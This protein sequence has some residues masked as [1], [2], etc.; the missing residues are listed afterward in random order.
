[1]RPLT[2]KRP[3]SSGPTSWGV[4]AL[5]ALVVVAE[6]YDLIV[7]GALLPSLLTEPGWG[8]DNAGAGTVGSLVHVGVSAAVLAA[9]VVLDRRAT[10][11]GGR[12]TAE[13]VGSAA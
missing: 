6:G 2:L 9:L 12:S 8:P 11:P 4:V 5:C 1:M 7:F 3:A 10:R 13:A